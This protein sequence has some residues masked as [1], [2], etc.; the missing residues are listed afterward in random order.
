MDARFIRLD[1]EKVRRLRSVKGWT[2][3]ELSLNAGLSKRTLERAESGAPIQAQTIAAIA[4]ALD[5]SFDELFPSRN[6]ETPEAAIIT[7]SETPSIQPLRVFLCHAS[8]DKGRVRELYHRLASY[9]IDPWLDERKLLPGQEWEREIGRAVRNSDVVLVCISNASVTKAGFVQKEIRFALD[10][11]DEKPEGTIFIIPVRLEECSVPERLRRWQWVNLF[12]ESEYHSLF[13]AL[14]E[15]ATSLGHPLVWP[16]LAGHGIAGVP[17]WH[18]AEERAFWKVR[19][20][21]DAPSKESVYQA[22]NKRIVIRGSTDDALLFLSFTIR[23]YLVEAAS[24]LIAERCDEAMPVWAEDGSALVGLLLWRR[25]ELVHL[26]VFDDDVLLARIERLAL[27]R[28]I[29]SYGKERP[30]ESVLSER[31][32]AL[33]NPSGAACQIRWDES[34]SAESRAWQEKY[35]F[36]SACCLAS[37]DHVVQAWP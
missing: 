28:A 5:I 19:V 15:R 8:G 20:S 13:V 23:H 9:G 24:E 31:A 16:P 34:V 6:A 30:P 3:N 36:I 26:N 18:R 21:A 10:V 33:R 37:D 11:A 7:P 17:S 14:R 2:Q 27:M 1:G 29:L 4:E 35:G 12:E 22:L 32:L 25:N